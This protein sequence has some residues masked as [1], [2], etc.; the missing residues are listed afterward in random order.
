MESY[1]LFFII[2]VATILSPGPGVILTLT[3]AIRYGTSGAIGGIL[4]IAF[5]TFIVAGVSATSLGVI[6]ATSAVAF[7]IMKYIGARRPNKSKPALEV[8]KTESFS[9]LR[10]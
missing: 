6:L 3:N 10:A 4:G 5:G 9:L 1:I 8:R 2:A 7:S